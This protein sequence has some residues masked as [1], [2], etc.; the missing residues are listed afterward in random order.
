VQV[1]PADLARK[2]IRDMVDAIT[3]VVGRE[4]AVDESFVI[5]EIKSYI[6]GR[7]FA[8]RNG[9]DLKLI[10][11]ARKQKP[12]IGNLGTVLNGLRSKVQW[13]SSLRFASS[14]PKGSH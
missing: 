12:G 10:Q 5:N 6:S 4:H 14:L 11:Y 13:I 8:E 2:E 1:C 7:D 3:S 9:C